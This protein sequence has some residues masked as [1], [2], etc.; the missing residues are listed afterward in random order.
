MKS[1]EVG[2][3]SLPPR[4]EGTELFVG[5]TLVLPRDHKDQ[6]VIKNQ[7]K[8][9]SADA[10]LRRVLYLSTSLPSWRLIIET[11]IRAMA[12]PTKPWYLTSRTMS[13]RLFSRGFVALRLLLVS[14]PLVMVLRESKTYASCKIPE[15]ARSKGESPMLLR[16]TGPV[17]LLA[18]WRPI[19]PVVIRRTQKIWI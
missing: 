1:V 14:N 16:I 18:P 7:A 19:P 3:T 9:I 13:K 15:V 17:E 11:M 8:A 12:T 4:K 2:L 5:D 10:T 6:T